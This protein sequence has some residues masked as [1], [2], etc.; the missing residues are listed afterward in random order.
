MKK[1]VLFLFGHPY[2]ESKL[3]TLYYWVAVSMYI[4]AVALLLITA[5]LTGD[6]GFWMSFIMNIVGF[7]IIFRV[8]YGL[9]T[10][11]NQMI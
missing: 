6:I 4:I 2:R 7:P 1:M 11:V 10:R 5:I 9:V 3:L 8:V